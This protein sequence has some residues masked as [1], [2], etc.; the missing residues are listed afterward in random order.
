MGKAG[1]G[2]QGQQWSSSDN[3]QQKAKQSTCPYTL[4]H[5]H[6][7]TYT[8][9]HKGRVP[10]PS[11]SGGRTS[12]SSHSKH[13]NRDINTERVQ[14][15][16]PSRDVGVH[17]CENRPACD[18]ATVKRAEEQTGRGLGRG[19]DLATTTETCS[20]HSHTRH[21]QTCTLTRKKNSKNLPKN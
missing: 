12:L 2:L 20:I 18:V 21:M 4:S 5:T 10:H 7:Y 6:I 1:R 17:W 11:F 9:T 3:S 14:L 15:W 8:H 16:T 13:K 19:T